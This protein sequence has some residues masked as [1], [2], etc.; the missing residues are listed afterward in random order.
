M[1]EKICLPCLQPVVG[2]HANSLQL[3]NYM[4]NL[5]DTCKIK[6]AAW[7]VYGNHRIL[8]RTFEDKYFHNTMKRFYHCGRVCV[9][10]SQARGSAVPAGTKIL[11][12]TAKVLKSWVRAEFEVFVL[13][14][15]LIISQ[16]HHHT[17]GNTFPQA[18]HE[19]ETLKNGKNCQSI[20]L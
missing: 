10:A 16:K 7:Y 19:R 2:P 12:L 5:I 18:L 8:K 13:F 11:T 20:S 4:A 15:K 14:L 17:M 3:D 6:T 9:P 1:R